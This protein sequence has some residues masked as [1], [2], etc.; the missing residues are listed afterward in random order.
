MERLQTELPAH[1][2]AAVCGVSERTARRW[3]SGATSC[4]TAARRLVWLHEHGRIFPDAWPSGWRAQSNG[5]LDIGHAAALSWQQIDWYFY[6][7][8]CWYKLLELI[9]RIEARL[10]ALAR[11]APTADVIDLER[12]RQELRELKARQFVLPADFARLYQLP[13][14]ETHRQA[15]C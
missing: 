15:G 2:I 12:Y 1:Q 11:V 3:L 4:P 13:E 8:Q 5:T 6:S 10:D 7:V 14:R 9:P